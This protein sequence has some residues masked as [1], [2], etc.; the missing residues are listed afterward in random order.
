MSLHITEIPCEHC[1]EATNRDGK[2]LVEL[3]EV[4]TNK[5]QKVRV[6]PFCDDESLLARV[7]QLSDESQE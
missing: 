3:P 1:A 2:F 7:A 5:K 4:T 6:C